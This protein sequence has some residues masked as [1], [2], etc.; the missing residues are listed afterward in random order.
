M[1]DTRKLLSGKTLLIALLSTISVTIL[2]VF[3]SGLTTHRSFLENA[4][5]SL[6]V[7]A[8]FLFLFL[9]FGLYNGLNVYDN[10]SH[11][12]QLTWKNASK[13]M[14]GSWASDIVGNMGAPEIDGDGI[15]GIIVG[16]ILW[17][18]FSIL[19]IILL[20]FL[21]AIVW[22]TFTLLLIA[23]Y[24]IMI[25]SLKLIFTKSPECESDLTKSVTYGLGYSI[26]Y[27]GWIYAIIYLSILA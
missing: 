19:L 21:H 9:T 18:I 16:I 27:V 20:V 5:I 13:Q 26:L 8:I 7:L 22:A 2:L 1:K 6:T 4:V 23:I 12:L 11:K 10:Y 17:I 3:V 14:P 24:W 25:R 15:G